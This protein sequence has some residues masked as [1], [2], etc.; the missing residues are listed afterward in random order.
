MKIFDKIVEIVLLVLPFLKR[1]NAS[2]LKEFSQLIQEQYGFLVEQLEKALKDYFTLS[3]RVKV[4]HEEVVALR[5]QLADALNERC[6]VAG[7]H[8]RIPPKGRNLSV[9]KKGSH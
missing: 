2:E 6:L 7:C 9:T 4:L 3:D 1:K 5:Q 8:K